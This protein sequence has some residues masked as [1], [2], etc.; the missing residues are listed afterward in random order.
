MTSFV[1]QNEHFFAIIP[2]GGVGSRLWP[3]SRADAPKFLLDLTGSGKSLLESTYDRLVPVTGPERIFVVTGYAHRN[4]VTTQLPGVL[5]TNIFL[6]PSPKDSTAAICI[7]AAILYR[8]DPDAIVGSFPADHLVSAPAEFRHVVREA[9][10]VA[11]RGY[12]TTIGITPT[13]PSEAFGYIEASDPID[14]QE[15]SGARHVARFVEKPARALAE[16]YFA[17]GT[18]LWNAGMFISKASVLLD[19]L[20][21][22]RPRLAD[23]VDRIADVWGTAEQFIVKDRLWDELEKV[24]ID[25]AIAEPAARDGK[26]AVV[27]GDFGWDDVGDFSAIA[28][29]LANKGSGNLAILGDQA[30]VISDRSSGIVVGQS[31]RVVAVIGLEDVVVVDTDDALLVTNAANAQRIKQMVDFLRSTGRGDVL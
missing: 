16:Q 30:R 28:R 7:A 29:H 11:E 14:P 17:D 26:V 4:A 13:E 6:E 31:D 27:P 12:I 1:P 15:F 23:A 24:A 18:H 25:Y 9:I 8:R 20:R 19:V 2:A 10:S 5:D 3:L 22:N 21:E